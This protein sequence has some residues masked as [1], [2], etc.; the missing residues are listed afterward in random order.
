MLEKPVN[1]FRPGDTFEPNSQIS[2]RGRKSVRPTVSIMIA[3]PGSKGTQVLFVQSAKDETGHAWMLPQG[4]IKRGE[5][6]DLA[7][8]REFKE[9]IGTTIPDHVV[10]H[11]LGQYPNPLPRER[12]SRANARRKHIFCIGAI[13]GSLPI[14]LGARDEITNF[15]WVAS[16]TELW[17]LLGKR[18][19]RPQKVI[20][21][22]QVINEAYRR[23]L[24]SWSCE[25]MLAGLL[26]A[27]EYRQSA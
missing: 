12:W 26:E 22:C 5:E 18:Q 14:S 23:R 3:Q 17:N 7:A 20:H 6:I 11:A 4:G 15:D 1:G 25:T 24:V 9:E 10:F 2:L 19:D 21:T 27:Q 13:V 16:E 8:R